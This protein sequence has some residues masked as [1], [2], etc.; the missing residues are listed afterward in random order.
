MKILWKNI[1]NPDRPQMTIWLIY[2]AR[3]VPKATNTHAEYVILTALLQQQCL[4]ER[5]SVSHYVYIV[6]F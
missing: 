3:W 4:H 1:A 2:I 6:L 5:G